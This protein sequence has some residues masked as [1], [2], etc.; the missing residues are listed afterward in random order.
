MDHI[1]QMNKSSKECSPC[2]RITYLK[3]IS[4]ALNAYNTEIRTKELKNHNNTLII[5]TQE[6]D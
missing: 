3:L 2:F 1:K 5:T 4:L 6:Q